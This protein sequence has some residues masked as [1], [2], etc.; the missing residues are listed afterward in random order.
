VPAMILIVDDEKLLAKTLSNALKEAGYKTATATTAETAEKQIFSGKGFDLI[1]LDNK[2]VKRSGLDIVRKMRE[3]DVRSK[4]ILMTAYDS[5]E[6]RSEAKKLRVS[7]Y[8][9]KP[10]D[11]PSML[12][13]V[14]EVIEGN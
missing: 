1:L 11:L 9:K 10:F 5:P 7:R 8:V 6:V 13:I 2:L 12:D 14:S 3:R 4:V